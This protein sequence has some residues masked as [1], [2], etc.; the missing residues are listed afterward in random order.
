[1]NPFE[2][3]I[4][5]HAFAIVMLVG[6]TAWYL[7]LIMLPIENSKKEREIELIYNKLGRFY[8]PLQNALFSIEGEE[9][10]RGRDY[11]KA[12]AITLNR[13]VKKVNYHT[14]SSTE[15]RSLIRRFTTK[16]PMFNYTGDLAN[17]AGMAYYEMAHLLNKIEALISRDIKEFHR[18]LD[19]KS[20]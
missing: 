3:N 18:K 16:F 19:E 9:E 15:L 20:P 6:I 7:W 12:K 5:W 13:I 10:D 17:D 4:S 1:M 14:L 2:F 11:I 8:V